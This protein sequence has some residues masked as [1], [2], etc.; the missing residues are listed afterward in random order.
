MAL[1]PTLSLPL[2]KEPPGVGFHLLHE[3]TAR[4]TRKDQRYLRGREQNATALTNF[5]Q[6]LI[7]TVWFD[8]ANEHLL[9]A[10]F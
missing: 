10:H 1:E 4:V 5:Y 8:R 7:R 3:T 9:T 2:R 6:T